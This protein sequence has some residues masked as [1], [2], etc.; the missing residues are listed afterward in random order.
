MSTTFS[1]LNVFGKNF[2]A[3]GRATSKQIVR[4]DRKSEF[5]RDF[6]PVLVKCKFNEDPIKDKGTI[7]FT[8]FQA[9]KGEL[10]GSGLNSKS[11]EILCMPWLS[12]GLMTFR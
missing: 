2:H 12:A 10:V 7:V 9:F 4:S 6:M 1:P 11:S 8:T 5:I 3:Q